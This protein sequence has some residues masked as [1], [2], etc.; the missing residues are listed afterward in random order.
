MWE[1][2]L[3]DVF[4][5]CFK[6]TTNDIALDQLIHFCA[7]HMRAENLACFGIKHRFYHAFRFAQSDRLTIAYE[8]EAAHFD[9]IAKLFGFGLCI[10]NGGNL[11]VAIGAACDALGAVSYTHLT[12]PTILLV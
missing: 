3:H 6:L 1:D 11:R 10:A 9:I 7:D 2:R 8:V 5:C 4:F 12:L